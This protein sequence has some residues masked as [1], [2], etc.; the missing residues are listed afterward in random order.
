M[1]VV[2]CMGIGESGICVDMVGRR[3]IVFLGDLVGS[4]VSVLCV[5]FPCGNKG[6]QIMKGKHFRK[7]KLFR[8]VCVSIGKSS[9][10]VARRRFVSGESERKSCASGGGGVVW[11]SWW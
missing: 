4:M 3:R 8:V 6:L 11:A 9:R 5:L 7:E 1:F 2:W 10:R